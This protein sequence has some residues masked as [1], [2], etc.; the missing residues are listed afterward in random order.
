[1]SERSVQHATFVIE[2]TYDASPARVFGAFATTEA[3]AKWFGDPD[4][5]S[6]DLKVDFRVGGREFNTGGPPGGPVFTYEAFYQDIVPNE[7]IVTTYAM[8][9]DGTP[10]SASVT[11]MELV[12]EGSGT[13]LTLTEQGAYLDAID[14]PQI[15]EGG[16]RDLLDSLANYLQ[17]ESATVKS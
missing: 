2:R 17:R 15:R 1:M 10:I 11:T 9:K 12:P 7:R 13:L 4:H 6:S 14:T 8:Q 3:K 16:M 5:P